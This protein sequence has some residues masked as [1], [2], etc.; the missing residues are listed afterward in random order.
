VALTIL[1][2]LSVF[3]GLMALATLRTENRH[4]GNGRRFPENP[5]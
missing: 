2:V 4:T 5:A 3:G 1:S